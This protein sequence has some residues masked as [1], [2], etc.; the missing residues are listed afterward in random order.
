MNPGSKFTCFTP[1]ALYEQKQDMRC[2]FR[3][4]NLYMSANNKISRRDGG[5]RRSLSDSL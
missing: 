2:A 5:I 1:N 4:C 3:V